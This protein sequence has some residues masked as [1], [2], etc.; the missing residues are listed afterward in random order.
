[1]TNINRVEFFQKNSRVHFF[2]YHKRNGIFEALKVEPVDAKHRR[3][4]SNWLRHVGR[5]NNNGAK[6]ITEL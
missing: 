2:F 5:M 1:M 3:Y 4:K 6:N